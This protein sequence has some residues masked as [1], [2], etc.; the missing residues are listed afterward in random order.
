MRGI[1]HSQNS[2]SNGVRGGRGREAGVRG[3]E[4]LL[5]GPHLVRGGHDTDTLPLLVALGA[6]LCH[7]VRGVHT[8]TR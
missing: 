6:P 5:S 8:W 4:E 1:K 3:V 7:L 2:R